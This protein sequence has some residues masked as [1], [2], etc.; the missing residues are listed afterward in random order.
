MTT[1]TFIEASGKRHVVEGRDGQSLM[2][3]A[4]GALVPGIVGDCGGC[5]SCATCHVQIDADWYARLAPPEDMERDMLEGAVEPTATSRL[6]C[7]IK[8][9]PE[10]NGLVARIPAGQL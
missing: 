8:L 1:I 3:A 10:L 5:C 7:Q 2:E 4:T 9:A 6:C